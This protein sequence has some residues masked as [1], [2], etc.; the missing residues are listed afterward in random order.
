M[1]TSYSPSQY[2]D[3]DE[4]SDIVGSY[5]PNSSYLVL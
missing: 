2:D 4:F 1:I 3:N 5:F